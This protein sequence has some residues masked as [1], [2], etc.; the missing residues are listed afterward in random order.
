MSHPLIGPHE[1]KEF[2]L[3]DQGLKHV[4][5]FCEI[6]PDLYHSFTQRP[7]FGCI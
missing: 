6:I 4:A 3:I 1:G 2:E 5:L 7:D